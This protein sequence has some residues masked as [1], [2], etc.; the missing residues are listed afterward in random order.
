MK[1]HVDTVLKVVL[2]LILLMPIL[3]ATGAFPPPT[4]D[5][6][7]TQ[8]AYTFIM[9]LDDLGAYINYAMVVTCALALLALWTRRTPLAALL[10]LPITVNVVGFHLFL[11][12]GLFTLGA[13]LGNIMLAINVYFLWKF[14]NE[15]R[16]LLRK[17]V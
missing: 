10:I 14:R 6:Y 5:M 11:D 4:A 17:T 12:G 3:G 1:K 8:D 2:S 9:L 13:L 7:N 16:F 15:Y